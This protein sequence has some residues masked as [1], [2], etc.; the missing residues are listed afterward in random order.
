MAKKGEVSIYEVQKANKPTIDDVCEQ[1]LTDP[2]LRGGMAHLLEL[3]KELRMKPC[4]SHTNVW[5]CNYKSKRVAMYSIGRGDGWVKNWAKIKIYT[6]DVNDVERFLL[7]LPGE[8]RNEYINNMTCTHCGDCKP[9]NLTLLGE[10]LEVCWDIGYRHHNPTQ[11]QFGWIEK[12]IIARRE[13]IKD[14]AV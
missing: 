9:H 10:P 1:L 13:Y 4:W 8:M 6:T 11:E 7:T 12:F 2:V 5:N 3:S 14:T